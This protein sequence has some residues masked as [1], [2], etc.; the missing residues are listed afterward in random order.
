MALHTRLGRLALSPRPLAPTPSTTRV[1][2]STATRSALPPQ[3]P[4]YIPVPQ[5]PLSSEKKP[6]RV[7]GSLPV[8]RKVFPLPGDSRKVLPDY[9]A[10]TYPRSTKPQAPETLD[11]AHP[12]AWKRLMAENRRTNLK[13]GL[14]D[15]WTRKEMKEKRKSK[16]GAEKHAAHVEAA[17][18]P[19]RV[20]DFLT[21]STV[22]KGSMVTEVVADPHR[23][24]KAEHSRTVTARLARERRELRRDALVELYMNARS[25]MVTEKQLEE[26]VDKVFNENFWRD[27]QRDSAWDEWGPQ[28]GIFDMVGK[29]VRDSPTNA[30]EKT[31]SDYAR[32]MRRQKRT[33]EELT[34]GKMSEREHTGGV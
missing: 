28:S 13:S 2:S 4:D 29:V 22:L 3:S 25:F 7:R 21:R 16:V 31:T 5:P 6:V 24:R 18:R 32:N 8:P 17:T 23:F 15:L 34:G 26:E 33:A 1:I 11:P 12:R 14:D 20:D 19:E 27:P 9:V 30:M 10:E